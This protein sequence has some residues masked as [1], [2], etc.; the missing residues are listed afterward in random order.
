MFINAQFL[1]A[2]YIFSN[3]ANNQNNYVYYTVYLMEYL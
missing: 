2:K 3:Y 1:K